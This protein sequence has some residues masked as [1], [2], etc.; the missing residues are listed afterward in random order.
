MCFSLLNNIL[1]NK[2]LIAIIRTKSFSID[3]D[4]IVAFEV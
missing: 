4:K 1:N 2:G 3:D